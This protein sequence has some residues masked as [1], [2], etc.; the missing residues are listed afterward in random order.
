MNQT[1]VL[2]G[3]NDTTEVLAELIRSL[4]F[5][6]VAPY[7]I[8]QCRPALGN[9][10]FTVPVEESLRIVQEAFRHCSGL[11]KRARFIMSHATGKIEVVG[12][13]EGQVFMRYHQAASPKNLGRCMAFTSN[14]SAMWFDDYLEGNLDR[15]EEG[16][17][18]G[19]RASEEETA[20]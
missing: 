17:E 9:R 1:P 6:G 18:S 7:Y 5:I 14:E 16:F 11:A 8:F 15:R 13:L 4:S 20:A 10:S 12:H 3:I 2:A 19:P